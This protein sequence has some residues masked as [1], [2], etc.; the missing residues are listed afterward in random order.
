[1]CSEGVAYV[2][3]RL[4]DTSQAHSKS[5]KETCYPVDKYGNRVRR[6]IR[7][8]SDSLC[9]STALIKHWTRAI[10]GR[11]SLFGFPM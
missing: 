11:K 3:T 9:F 10:K 1:M 2:K 6:G 5:I 7:K 8:A 4:E